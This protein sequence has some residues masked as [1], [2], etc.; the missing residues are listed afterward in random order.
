MTTGRLCASR[1][2]GAL[3][4]FL[5]LV[6]VA[7]AAPDVFVPLVAVALLVAP[8]I[9]WRAYVRLRRAREVADLRRRIT[10]G[11][12]IVS[13]RTAYNAALFLAIGSTVTASLGIFV[14]L[15][16]L[17]L[18]EAIPREVFLVVLSYPP[19]LATGPAFDWLATVGRLE[20]VAAEDAAA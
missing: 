8:A 9:N 15:R 18:V 3:V 5:L 14:A 17:N 16:A 10:G 13:L 11:E 4:L 7:L 6:A 12:P 19:F 20:A 2:I 1:V